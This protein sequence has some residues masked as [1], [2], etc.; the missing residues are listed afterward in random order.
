MLE[1]RFLKFLV[2]YENFLLAL[3]VL[4][5]LEIYKGLNNHN[6]Y[7]TTE[8]IQILAKII[9]AGVMIMTSKGEMI[10]SLFINCTF[11]NDR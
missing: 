4:F 8:F 10:C 3:Y 5:Q 9:F 11:D 1:L 6:D 7:W 2:W